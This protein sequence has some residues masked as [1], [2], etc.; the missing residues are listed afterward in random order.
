MKSEKDKELLEKLERIKRAIPYLEEAVKSKDIKKIED[1]LGYL[2]YYVHRLHKKAT[3]TSTIDSI[4][5]LTNRI[6]W[7]KIKKDKKERK[8][9]DIKKHYS[10]WAKKYDTDV[11]LAIF[12]EEKHI[13]NFIPNIKNKE[14]LDFGCGT[15]RWAIR[16]AKKGAKVTAIDLTPAMINLAKKKAKK[17]R[18][19]IDF[20]IQD[21]TKYYPKKKFDLIIS[22]LVLDHIKKLEKIVKVI[23]KA[24]K[25]GTEVIISNVHPE[26]MIKY[27]NPKTGKTGGYILENYKTDQFFHPLEEYVDVFLKYGFILTKTKTLSPTKEDL[28]IKKMRKFRG[29]EDKSQV[30]LM[31]FKKI[32]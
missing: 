31:K 3:E 1:S 19:N 26:T 24:S 2:F 11:N 16:F 27:L 18:L 21:L 4:Q 9:V 15:G 29:L 28:E 30:L 20:S 10:L 32:Q 14:V 17:S 23:D 5:R 6:W 12:L 7:F 8:Y 22:M 13:K 25:I